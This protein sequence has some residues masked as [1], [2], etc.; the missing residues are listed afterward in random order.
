MVLTINSKISTNDHSNKIMVSNI[1]SRS[2]IEMTE[3]TS[4]GKFY[5]LSCLF[6]NTFWF[7]C[8]HLLLF[9]LVS[10]EFS[11]LFIQSTLAFFAIIFGLVILAGLNNPVNFAVWHDITAHYQ[12]YPDISISQLTALQYFYS[13]IQIIRSTMPIFSSAPK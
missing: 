1:S 11:E 10:V 2:K 3:L 12:S 13:M 4:Q 5:F 6:G 8:Q 7:V 9:Y